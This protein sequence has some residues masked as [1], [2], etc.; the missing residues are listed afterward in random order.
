MKINVS[1]ISS[2]NDLKKTIKLIDASVADGIHVDL[3]DGMYTGEKNFDIDT[4]YTY[5]E[6]TKKDLDVHLMVNNPSNYFDSLFDIN[7]KCIYIHPETS[8]N[9]DDDL[10]KLKT[11]GIEKGIAINPSE[12]IE[13]FEKYYPVV[14]RVLL[15]SVVPGKGGQKFLSKT[16]EKLEILAEYR[17]KY[18]FLIYVDGGINE[19]TIKE[20]DLA[21][22]VISGSYI[23][24]SDNYSKQIIK[25]KQKIQ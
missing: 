18:H 23:C 13:C 1:Y 4:L 12:D 24:M 10:K 6:D 3:I 22:G 9:L 17:K 14:D 20:V 25:L 8:E 2:K 16:K 5:F 15:M 7:P 19:D 21:D 11:F